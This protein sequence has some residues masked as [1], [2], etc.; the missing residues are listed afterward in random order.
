MLH[1]YDNEGWDVCVGDFDEFAERNVMLMKLRRKCISEIRKTKHY[2]WAVIPE[3]T[4]KQFT[5]DVAT[6][7][8]CKY[9]TTDDEFVEWCKS[10]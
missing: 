5:L 7:I 6:N 1:H 8:P 4:Q 2:T 10:R 9:H 3:E